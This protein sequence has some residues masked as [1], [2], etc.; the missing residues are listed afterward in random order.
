MGAVVNATA[1]RTPS[2]NVTGELMSEAASDA[3][4]ARALLR[5]ADYL[6]FWASRWMGSLGSQIQS[7]AMGWQVYALSRQT[8][9]RRASAPSTSA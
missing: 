6:R 4:S 9:E 5:E 8:L 1:L 2:A 3:P 7:V